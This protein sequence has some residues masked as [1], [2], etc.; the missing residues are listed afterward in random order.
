MKLKFSSDYVQ[1]VVEAAPATVLHDTVIEIQELRGYRAP[2]ST[3]EEE[4][5]QYLSYGYTTVQLSQAL[6][7][8]YDTVETHRKNIMRKLGATNIVAAVAYA[9]RQGLME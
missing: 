9:L 8:S 3:R 1:T 4:M 2:L 6:H 5:L 7:I